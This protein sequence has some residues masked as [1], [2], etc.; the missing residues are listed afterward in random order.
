MT[1]AAKAV[2]N[3]ASAEFA[4][5]F[6]S[7]KQTSALIYVQQCLPQLFSLSDMIC[8]GDDSV[9]RMQPEWLMRA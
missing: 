5:D 6:L 2:A 4:P 3:G 7:A 8:N 9:L 1:R